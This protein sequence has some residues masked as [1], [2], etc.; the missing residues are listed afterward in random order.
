MTSYI[1]IADQV[2]NE[3][4]KYVD[5]IVQVDHLD[6]TFSKEELNIACSILRTYDLLIHESDGSGDF[7]KFKITITGQAVA[8][9]SG[10]LRKYID[11]LGHQNNRN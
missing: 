1:Y 6:L 2:L 11:E 3:C 8:N 7:N 4:N 9:S 10:G 5:K